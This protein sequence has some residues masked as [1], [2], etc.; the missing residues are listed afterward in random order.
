MPK[1]I[2][3][4]IFTAF[5]TL[6]IAF[7]SAQEKK[8]VEPPWPADS[9]YQE[10]LYWW[11]NIGGRIIP[12]AEE[13]PEDKYDFK[14]QKDE[15]T[16]GQNLLHVASG[17][18][19]MINLIK[20]STVGYTGDDDSLWK[21]Y[22]QKTDIV[23]Y[24][25]Q[26]VADGFDLIKAQGDSGLTHEVKYPWANQMVHASFCWWTILWHAGDHYGQLA[27]YYRLNGMIP[28]ASR[29]RK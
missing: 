16:F 27:V 29:P 19:T 2:S 17:Y 6:F 5:A 28:P 13:F 24:L 23:K 20:G 3:S 11:N 15:R 8:P 12:M 9:P 22:P 4:F 21:K 18:Y 25:K 10:L 1:N 7:A 26:S 14:A